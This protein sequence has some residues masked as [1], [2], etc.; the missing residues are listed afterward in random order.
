MRVI[1]V[2]S[3]AEWDVYH[4]Q[5]FLEIPEDIREEGAIFLSNYIDQDIKND[6][7]KAQQREGSQWAFPHHHLWGMFIRN[8]LRRAGFNDERL[9]DQNWDDYYIP[10]IEYAIGIRTQEGDYV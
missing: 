6:I 5:K 7:L 2:K 1:I 3:N 9:P 4:K 10:L 8:A